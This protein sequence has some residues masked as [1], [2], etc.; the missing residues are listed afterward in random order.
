MIHDTNYVLFLGSVEVIDSL[1]NAINTTHDTLN[2]SRHVPIDTST[3]DITDPQQ[4]SVQS[5]MA[6]GCFNNATNVE[7]ITHSDNVLA[8]EFN[9]EGHPPTYWYETLDHKF[10]DLFIIAGTS[11]LIDDSDTESNYAH[12]YVSPHQ[13]DNIDNDDLFRVAFTIKTYYSLVHTTSHQYVDT[14]SAVTTNSPQLYSLQ[15]YA[16]QIIGH[17]F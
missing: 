7:V 2:F 12:T 13:G 8:L 4:E 10:R 14:R 16:E 6:W 9:T 15:K 1:F 17:N 5:F 3:I 11:D